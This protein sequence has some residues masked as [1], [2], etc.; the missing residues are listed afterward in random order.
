MRLENETKFEK[1]GEIVIMD[2]RGDITSLSEVPLKNAYHNDIERI[3]PLEETYVIF[4][5]VY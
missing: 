3:F 1:H 4:G 2:I 5:I